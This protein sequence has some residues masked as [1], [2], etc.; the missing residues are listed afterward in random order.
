MS[1]L[2]FSPELQFPIANADH[3]NWLHLTPQKEDKQYATLH[4]LRINTQTHPIAWE[5]ITTPL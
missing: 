5:S 3:S 1:I 4:V 2:T